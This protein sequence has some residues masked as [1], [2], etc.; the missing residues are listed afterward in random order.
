MPAEKPAERVAERRSWKERERR[1][2]AGGADCGGV[3]GWRSAGMDKDGDGSWGDDDM[4]SGGSWE[5][6]IVGWTRVE[7]GNLRRVQFVPVSIIVR[8]VVTS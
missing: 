2:V 6:G 4:V 5:L 8:L 1:G 7:A 3:G